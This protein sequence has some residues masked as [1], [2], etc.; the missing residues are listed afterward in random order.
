MEKPKQQMICN[1]L[2]VSHVYKR[3]S[4]KIRQI[5]SRYLWVLAVRLGLGWGARGLMGRGWKLGRSFF[6]KVTA[7]FLYFLCSKSFGRLFLS[8]FLSIKKFSLWSKKYFYAFCIVL[9]VSLAW[10]SRRKNP[11][12]AML[13]ISTVLLVNCG[14]KVGNSF[15]YFSLSLGYF[16]GISQHQLAQ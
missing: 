15:L 9:V 2:T 5:L 11:G 1:W 12:K 16:W 10:C 8:F 4:I 14:L 7:L 6:F 13:T 3:E